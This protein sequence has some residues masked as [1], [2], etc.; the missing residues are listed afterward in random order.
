MG[1][2][3]KAIIRLLLA[4]VVLYLLLFVLSADAQWLQGWLLW[5][6]LAATVVANLVV[7]RRDPGLLAE[8]MKPMLRAGQPL[9]DRILLLLFV[10]C[11]GAWYILMPLQHRQQPG[12]SIPVWLQAAGGLLA[13]SGCVIIIICFAQNSYLST[14]VRIQSERGH[15]LVDTGLYS[16]VRHPMYAGVLCLLPGAALLLS[17]SWGLLA[18]IAGIVVL[19]LRAV[20]EEKL[21][22]QQL[23][24]YA[25]YVKRVRHRLIPYIL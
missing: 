20:Q 23:P 18:G 14:V 15:Q 5:G 8:R 10:A 25:D 17:S 12:T 24:G 3:A 22:C 21:L 4:F 1:I 16:I 6:L 2:F 13:L 11:Y 19:Y 9:I 7:L